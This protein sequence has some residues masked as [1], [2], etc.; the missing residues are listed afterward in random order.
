MI[1]RIAKYP[2]DLLWRIENKFIRFIF[3]GVL[4]TAFGYFL[5]LLFIW[6]G[7]HYSLS[8][9]FSQI[10]GVLFNYKTT[11]YIVFET[12]TN[13]LIL[14][15]FLVYG[16]IYLVNVGELFLLKH[17]GIYSYILSQEYLSFVHNLP[18]D[19]SKLSDAIGQAIVIIP[20]AFL[21]FL[22]NKLFVFDR[23]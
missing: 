18:I 6:L 3:V 23:K 20:N 13:K 5:F 12:K 8:L 4:N 17:S 22:L 21:G 15:F 10:L 14:H 16:F 2:I 11:G 9:L 1:K 19:K 7:L